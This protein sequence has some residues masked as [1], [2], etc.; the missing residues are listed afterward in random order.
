MYQ[1]SCECLSFGV[2]SERRR[3]P[4]DELG[5]GTKFLAELLQALQLP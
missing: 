4:G 3:K 1:T 5:M 2:E